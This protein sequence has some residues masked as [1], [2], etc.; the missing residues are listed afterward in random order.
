[1]LQLLLCWRYLRTRYIA[2][3]S[4][5][6]VML[7]VATM[8]VVNAVMAGFAHEMQDRIH[9]I[10]SD[11]V[12]DVRSLEGAPDAEAHM[13]RIERVAGR[14]IEGMSPTAHV[15]AMLGFYV[16]EQYVTRQVNVIGIDPSTYSSVSDF[17][18]YLQHPQNRAELDFAL[19]DGGYDAIDHQ[20][21]DPS[22][23]KPRTEM[24]AAGWPHRKKMAR[25]VREPAL[26]ADPALQSNPFAQADAAAAVNGQ[27]APVDL[28]ETFNPATDQHPGVVVGIAL[29]SYRNSDSTDSFLALPGD[30]VEIIYPSVGRPP[31]ALSAKFT[32]TDFYESKMNE[33]DTT[34]VF[35]PLSKLQALR[36]MVSPETG[37]GHFNSIQIKTRPGVDPALVRDILQAEFPPQWYI[38]STWQDKQGALLAAVQMETAVLNVLLFLIIAVAGFGILAIFY[39]IVVEKTRDIGVLKSLGAGRW[40]VM[41]IFLGYGLALGVSGAGVGLIGGLLFVRNINEI[42]DLLSRLTGRPVFDPA[43]YYFSRIPTIVEPFTVCWI[44][45]GAMAIAVMASVL[46]ARRAAGLHPVQ[47]L[48]WE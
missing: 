38:A 33:Y 3:A 10:L 31:K 14:Y 43:I 1:M 28:G 23:V 40:G 7:G 29:C 48:R 36:G 39:M 2:L 4:I 13:A 16:G 25:L 12:L 6:S 20:A 46:P 24:P 9:G 35:V 41:G 5:T 22:K 11:L 37:K 30:D 47:A 19:K 44:A 42:A 45:A 27:P 8:I 15:P 21:D 17:G 26:P 18:K 34:F 32:I